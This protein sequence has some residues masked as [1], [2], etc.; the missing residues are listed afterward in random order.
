[1]LSP[2]LVHQWQ[3]RGFALVNDVLPSELVAQVPSQLQCQYPPLSIYTSTCVTL[4][5]VREAAV[6]VYP[7]GSG[8]MRDDFGS[9]GTMCFPS[10]DKDLLIVNEIP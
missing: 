10:V 8:P 1:M 3:Q 9:G 6:R 4:P 5:Q 2:E 7:D